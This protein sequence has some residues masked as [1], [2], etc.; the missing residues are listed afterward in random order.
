MGCG[1]IQ[2]VILPTANEPKW[3]E[4]QISLDLPSNPSE[5]PPTLLLTDKYYLR[6][7]N[8]KL[9]KSSISLP[10]R[11]SAYLQ[12]DLSKFLV[13]G[14]YNTEKLEDSSECFIVSDQTVLPFNSLPRPTRRLRLL[15]GNDLIF[16]VGGVREVKGQEIILDYS[17]NF[18]CL[19]GKKWTSLP[20]VPYGVEYPACHFFAE[21]VFVVGGC[22]VNGMD[23]VV[24]DFVQVFDVRSNEWNLVKIDLPKAVYGAVTV[25]KDSAS[26]LLLGGVDNDSECS[27]MSFIVDR[28]NF[29]EICPVDT[30][31]SCFFPFSVVADEK[32]VY[33]VN[34]QYQVL[35]L[36]RLKRKWGVLDGVEE[37]GL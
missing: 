34:E 18:Q 5:H 35:C 13:A 25:A 30:E 32:F 8:N 24:V 16:A 21:K 36:E 28:G 10:T 15:K 37:N 27:C 22:V 11:E 4:D 1:S 2:K 6:I 14:G 9:F 26:F 12:V 3:K 7:S 29:E 23:L 20:D 17:D 33:A 31:V 19:N